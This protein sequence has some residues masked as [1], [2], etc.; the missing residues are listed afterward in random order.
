MSD[1]DPRLAQILD[2]ACLRAPHPAG[3][4]RPIEFA[5]RSE[6]SEGLA[7]VLIDDVGHEGPD[8]VTTACLADRW[9]V[10]VAD[11]CQVPVA[12]FLNAVRGRVWDLALGLLDEEAESDD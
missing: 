5:F 12:A 2:G 4:L 7:W 11:G 8:L 3:G 6:L 10:I 1:I 9:L